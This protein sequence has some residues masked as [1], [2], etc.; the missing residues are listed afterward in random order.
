[1]AVERSIDV[2]SVGDQLDGHPRILQQGDDRTRLAVVDRSHRVEQMRRHR[3]PG[4]DRGPG[5]GVGR[6]GVA[7]GRNHIR[8]NQGGDRIQCAAAFR[9][10][11]H[12]PDRPAAGVEH[13]S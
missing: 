7:N 10:Q 1:M 12:H 3:R 4:L 5:L 9:S 13:P 2:H 6:L 8:I 11:R